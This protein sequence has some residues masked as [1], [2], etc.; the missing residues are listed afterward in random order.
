KGSDLPRHVVR[1]EVPP[2]A[3]R[4]ETH[5]DD[6]AAAVRLEPSRFPHR[7]GR[8]DNAR[9]RRHDAVEQILRRQAEVK[10]DDFWLELFD[11]G[12]RFGVEWFARGRREWSI[13]I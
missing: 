4:L 11:E 13:W 5:R 6:R 9:L 7:S 2:M 1:K 10:T 3:A 8:G 12:T